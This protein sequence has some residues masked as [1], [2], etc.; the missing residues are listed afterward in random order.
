MPEQEAGENGRD[1]RGAQRETVHSALASIAGPRTSDRPGTRL[2]RAAPKQ[3]V[4]TDTLG[5]LLAVL[6]TAPGVQGS[7]AGTA[8][9]DLV[10][11]KHP[12]IRKVW[13]DGGYRRHLVEHAATPGVDMEITA[14]K[15]GTRGLSPIPKWW[16]V[17]R[18]YG[19]LMFHRRLA[20]DHAPQA[21]T[22]PSDLRGRPA[23]PA[24]RGPQGRT[25]ALSPRKRG[26]RPARR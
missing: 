24:S 4:V 22:H 14:R 12:G 2:S 25:C 18:T 8:L 10:A 15:P 21:A 11:A 20:R 5:L 26:R 9:L 1:R 7:I 3:S 19:W 16:A 23:L 6:V 13:G 17:E